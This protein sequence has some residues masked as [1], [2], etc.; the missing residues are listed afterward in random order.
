MKRSVLM[1]RDDVSGKK[2]YIIFFLLLLCASLLA[3]EVDR[4]AAAVGD[5]VILKSE[6]KKFFDDWKA[7]TQQPTMISED[8]A[9]QML[10]DEKLILEKAKKEGI[11]AKD[12]EI[13]M[14]L[15]QIMKNIES[16]FDSYQSFLTA[17]HNEGFTLGK[18]K[19]KY[20]EEISK[21]IIKETIIN[22][23]VFSKVSV[24]EYGKRQFYQTHLDSLPLRPR[25]M[26]VGSIVI[27]PKVSKESLDKALK[28]IEKIKA[29]LDENADFEELARKY[30]DCPS[31][32]NGGDLGYFSRG[33]MV[34]PFEDAAFSLNIGEV[35][36]PVKTQFGYHLIRVDDKRDG[37]VRAHHILVKTAITEQ[38]KKKAEDKINEV[39]KELTNGADF[40]KLAKEYS[41]SDEIEKDENI[42]QEYPVDQLKSMP[43][44][45]KAIMNLKE[46]EFS[47]VTEIKENYY[48]FKNLGYVK[49]R[50]YEYEE[51]SQ[52][53]E[54]MVLQEKR[55]NAL[56]KWLK[57]L[58]KEIFVKV[59]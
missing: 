7:S 32:G 13:E 29:E 8:D 21:Q 9:L 4:I 41:D 1:Y 23:E 26:K 15:E 35:S 38:D 55:Q 30:S 53:I 34:K 46:G 43:S 48:I 12:T 11:T 18:L 6:M 56:K 54:N 24:S 51:I 25:M 57:D 31:G 28:K 44:L 5:E 27:K 59:Y 58:R 20:R 39:Y 42:I 19:E 47:K 40:M 37:E 2:I 50:P 16:R 36:K 22:R 49:P 3:E 33:Q 45:G 10:I 17:L 52:Q 14:H